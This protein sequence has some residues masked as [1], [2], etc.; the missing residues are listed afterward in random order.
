MGESFVFHPLLVHFGCAYCANE[1]SL[2]VHFYFDNDQLKCAPGNGNLRTFFFNLAIEPV[3]PPSGAVKPGQIR[4]PGKVYNFMT[5]KQP[6]E[7]EEELERSTK[8]RGSKSVA[9]EPSHSTMRRGS[10]SG[11]TEPVNRRNGFQG[12]FLSRTGSGTPSQ[13]IARHLRAA[14]ETFT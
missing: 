2:R 13:G 10:K 7:E 3:P 6:R 14:L 12:P 1:Q 5:K 11:A 9:I 8:K 4:N